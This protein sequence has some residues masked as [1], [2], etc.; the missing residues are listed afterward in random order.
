MTTAF[1]WLDSSVL[2]YH[3]IGGYA[4]LILLGFLL[5]LDN[6]RVSIGLGTLTIS[7]TRQKHIALA[8][9]IC[10]SLTTIFGFVI[11]N[12]L[13][14]VITP[15]VQYVGPI[16]VGGYGAYVIFLN[17]FEKNELLLNG[18]WLVLGLPI[19][20]SF[21]NIMAGVALGAIG[22]QIIP[23]AIIIGTMSGLTSLIGLRVGHAL[24]KYLPSKADLIGGITLV[25]ISVTMVVGSSR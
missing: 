23:Y 5:T 7:K 11:G 13:S 24:R 8:F 25:V 12:S 14:S 21:D 17:H 4:A 1:Y 16:A 10:E 9:G 18:L 19:S 22:F 6:F 3:L 2:D 20:L 15:W